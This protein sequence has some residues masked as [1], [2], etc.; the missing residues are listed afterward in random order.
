[1]VHRRELLKRCSIGLAASMLPRCL[2]AQTPAQNAVLPAGVTALVNIAPNWV[3]GQ[4]MFDPIG[5]HI[6]KGGK[7]RWQLPVM[8]AH[9]LGATVTAFHPSNRNHELR[10]PENAR[11]FDSGP[12]NFDNRFVDGRII[13]EWTFDVEGTYDY[14]STVHEV[15]GMVGRIVVG[16]PGGPAEQFPPGYGAKTGRAVVYP[17]EVKLLNACPSSEIMERDVVPYPKDLVTRPHPF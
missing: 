8:P 6:P 11:P 5:I 4:Q 10:I 3:E 15:Y 17:A 1:M 2:T 7:V 13:F 14:Y 16:K 12:I 9:M